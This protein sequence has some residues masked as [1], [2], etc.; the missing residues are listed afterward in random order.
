MKALFDVVCSAAFLYSILRVSTPILFAS[1]GAVVANTAGIPNI[2]LEGIMLTAA[3]L[4]MFG[5]AITGSSAAGLLLAL[6]GGTACAALI[7]FFTLYYRANVIL[8]GIAVNSLASGGT[9]ILLYLFSGSKGSS[10]SVASGVLPRIN[11]PLIENI[12]VLGAVISGHNILTY[13]SIISV[14]IVSL[15]LHKTA[16]G[17]HIRAVGENP[18]AADSVGINVTRVKARAVLLSGLLASMGGVFMSMG[19]V[20]WFARD[21]VAGRGWIAVAAEAMGR[22]TVAGTACAALLFGTADAFSNAA[23]TLGWPSTLVK[24]IPYCA[25]LAGLI[26]FSMRTYRRS[27]IKRA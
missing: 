26:I 1:M 4:G 2:A 11:L 12:P 14:V 3:F 23:G 16:L 19:Y 17:F 13:L 5:S 15:L 21:M 24:T 25:T 10:S 27:K 9:V 22:S 20:S 18:G 7:A 6:L 8:A